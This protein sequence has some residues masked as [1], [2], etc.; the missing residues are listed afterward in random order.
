MGF[1]D[2]LRDKF[3]GRDDDYYDDEYY[4]DE[5]YEDYDDEE[6]D[7]P[8]YGH[9]GLLGNSRRPEAESVSVHPRSQ[10]RYQSAYES[11]SDYDRP[12]AATGGYKPREA[13]TP[14]PMSDAGTRVIPRGTAS[15]AAMGRLPYYV[16]RPASYDDAQTI[17][18]RVQ[19]NQPVVLVLANT[20]IDAA[21]RILDFCYGLTVG[22]GGSMRELG[23]R[24][25]AVLPP[26]VD[27]MQSDL[28][29]LV[30]DG[31]LVR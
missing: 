8:D 29:K 23:D 19:T 21:K 16:V 25:F 10:S 5:D 3:A 18:R 15:Q 6:D 11:T 17:V 7:E 28:D 30:A 4:D 2:N 12:A 1:L 14:A 31:D 26:N 13:P 9:T 27:L 24:V 20:N 22:M